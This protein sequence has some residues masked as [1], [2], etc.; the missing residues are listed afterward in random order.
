[1]KTLLSAAAVAA[2]MTLPAA[3]TVERVQ[4]VSVTAD[5]T[6]IQNERAAG[7]W[8]TLAEDLQAAILARLTDRLADDGARIIIDI[9]EV[10]LASAFE[11][12]LNLQ[13]AVLVG[14]VAVTDN[15]DNANFNAYDLSVSLEGIDGVIVDG[16]IIASPFDVP[17]TYQRLVDIFADQVVARLDS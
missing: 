14:Q 3:A 4:D 13:D 12:S 11:R 2:L 15:T 16:Q 9:E 1:M 17:E 10:A 7:Y 5:L 6:A 8:G